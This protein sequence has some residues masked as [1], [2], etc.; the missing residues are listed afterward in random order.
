MNPSVNNPLTLPSLPLA[1]RSAL[2]SCAAIYF[3]LEGD[4]IFIQE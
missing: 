3:V 2:P 4:R 1:S